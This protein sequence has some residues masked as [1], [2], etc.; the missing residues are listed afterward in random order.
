MEVV[1]V[2][3]AV[4]IV[5]IVIIVKI[6]I[7]IIII[8]I[9]VIVIMVTIVMVMGIMAVL[10]GRIVTVEQDQQ[11][12]VDHRWFVGRT[13]MCRRRHWGSRATYLEGLVR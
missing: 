4:I 12:L 7:I 8:I 3:I 6:I 11:G 1:I 5:T 10:G 2:G 9:I 13:A